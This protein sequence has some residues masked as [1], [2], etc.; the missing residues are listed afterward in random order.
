MKLLDKDE[1]TGISTYFKHD[2]VTNKNII[3]E[4]QDVDPILEKNKNEAQVFDKRR[5]FWKVGE[6]P[7]VIC[8]KWADECGHP[9]FTKQWQEYALK[10]MDSAEY[11]KLNPNRIKLTR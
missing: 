9:A 1:F 6:I 8:Q 5:N 2:P 11:R 7:L 4:V 3:M 10:Q